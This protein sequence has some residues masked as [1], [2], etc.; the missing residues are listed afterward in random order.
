MAK[1][2]WDSVKDKLLLVEAWCRDGLIEDQIAKNLGIGITTLK[3]YKNRYPSFMAALKRGKEVVDTEVENSLFKR[4][5]GY[6]Y[7]EVTKELKAVLDEDGIPIKDDNGH[8]IKEMQITKAITK[9][10]VPDVTAQIFWLKNRKRLEWR[11]KQDI[12]LNGNINV[13]KVKE[14]VWDDETI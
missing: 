6:S 14:P 10:V 5:N 2:K 13:I 4:A 8:T 3:D 11:D 7:I 9:E 1:S 12:E